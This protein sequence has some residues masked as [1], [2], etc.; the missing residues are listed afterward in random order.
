MDN[1][2]C[3]YRKRCRG[4]FWGPFR[5][6][7]CL[8]G[9]SGISCV[10]W[11]A[12]R[13]CHRWGQSLGA[14]VWRWSSPHPGPTAVPEDI[15]GRAWGTPSSKEEIQEVSQLCLTLHRQYGTIFRS[16]LLVK[17]FV[18]RFILML[19]L[20]YTSFITWDA[21]VW[22]IL[23]LSC[24]CPECVGSQQKHLFW[25]SFEVSRIKRML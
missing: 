11:Q 16:V 7:P 24:V 6:W 17:N 15:V 12:G 10:A 21:A 5:G 1:G 23:C 13:T 22:W 14:L 4:R 2:C 9:S 20:T 19:I 25:L 3:T 8:G 18:H